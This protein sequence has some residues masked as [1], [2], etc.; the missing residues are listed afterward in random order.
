MLAGREVPDA[1]EAR[2][3]HSGSE[4]GLLSRILQPLLVHLPQMI[5]KVNELSIS[6]KEIEKK[7]F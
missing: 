3:H 1:L 4:S 6:L 7:K 2:A 5:Q